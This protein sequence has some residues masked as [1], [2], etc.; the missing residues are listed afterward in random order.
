MT[1]DRS[2]TVKK[3]KKAVERRKVNKKSREAEP[4]VLKRRKRKMS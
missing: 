4:N 2:N 1:K 3:L